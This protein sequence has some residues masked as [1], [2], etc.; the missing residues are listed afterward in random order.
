MA[1]DHRPG[2]GA[3]DEAKRWFAE[4]IERLERA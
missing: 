4:C 1:T 3:Q 2:A